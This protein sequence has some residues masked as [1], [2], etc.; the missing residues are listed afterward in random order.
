MSNKTYRQRQLAKIHIGCKELGLDEETYRQGLKTLTGKTSCADMGSAELGAVLEW[1]KRLG[2]KPKQRSR[3]YSPKTRDKEPGQKD[4]RDKLRALWIDM[5]KT[6]L[7]RDGS[8]RALGNW[9]RRMT[10]RYNDG[11]GYES[12]DWVPGWLVVKLIED[13]K[14]WKKRLEAAL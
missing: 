14:Q 10:A 7:L 11:I 2:W 1:L 6:G 4:A 13:L 3:R 8:E 9:V 12:T 5:A